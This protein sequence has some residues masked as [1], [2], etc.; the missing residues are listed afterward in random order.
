MFLCFLGKL[1]LFGT[2]KM[3]GG[4]GKLKNASFRRVFVFFGIIDCDSSCYLCT[5]AW[6]YD[7]K[8]LW[9]R[10]HTISHKF[11]PCHKGNCCHERWTSPSE[12]FPTSITIKN[13]KTFLLHI[14]L[15]YSKKNSSTWDVIKAVDLKKLQFFSIFW[16]I[17]WNP[18]RFQ[19]EKLFLMHV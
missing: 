10:S 18:F 14:K 9:E 19:V 8:E 7:V 3:G 15:N 1:K 12:T 11:P 16:L 5:F 4:L 6:I 2:N 13:S 17:D